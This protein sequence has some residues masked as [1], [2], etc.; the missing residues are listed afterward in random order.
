M[1]DFYADL[2]LSYLYNETSEAAACRVK[3]LIQSDA[4]ARSFYR[5]L[6]KARRQLHEHLQVYCPCK[7]V[8]NN[9]LHYAGCI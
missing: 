3:R 7:S 8:V 2:I 1:T 6:C 5:F 4:E 9:V